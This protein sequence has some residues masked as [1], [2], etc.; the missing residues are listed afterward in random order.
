M[1]M[2]LIKNATLLVAGMLHRMMLMCLLHGTVQIYIQIDR[3]IY[4]KTHAVSSI[5]A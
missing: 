1:S 4:R 2:R 3:R 5:M